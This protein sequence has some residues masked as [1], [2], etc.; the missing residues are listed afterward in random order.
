[1]LER[2]NT[3]EAIGLNRRASALLDQL[4]VTSFALCW[5]AIAIYT[6]DSILT[7]HPPSIADEPK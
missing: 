1:M 6:A 3:A 5:L 7:R 2:A 4:S